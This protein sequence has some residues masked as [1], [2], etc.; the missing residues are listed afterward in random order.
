ML[1]FDPNNP[2]VPAAKGMIV[3]L[4]ATPPV[5]PFL[6]WTNHSLAR[7]KAVEQ[8]QLPKSQFSWVGRPFSGVAAYSSAIAPS[9][10][11][12]LAVKH[13]ILQAM[14]R[15]ESS[16]PFFLQV[17]VSMSSGACAGLIASTA[18]EAIAQTQTL[19]E[20]KLSFTGAAKL[21]VKRNGYHGL[22]RGGVAIGWREAMFQS[23]WMLFAPYISAQ[24]QGKF[25]SKWMC[26]GMSS[27]IIGSLLG[28]TTSFCNMLRHR[29]QYALDVTAP[30]V[31]YRTICREVFRFR[32]ND[33][34]ATFM[35]RLFQGSV[36]R[37]M[38]VSVAIFVMSQ[39]NEAI[40]SALQRYSP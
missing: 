40:E 5:T 33:T 22:F 19:S 18:P 36:P 28:T 14:Q 1:N 35:L 39:A 26:D 8:N 29:K 37:C 20:K 11:V 6:N 32:P 3:G 31:S 24:M 9:A 13:G 16:L 10:A 15:E 21:I 38:A 34:S 25:S 27:F 12:T 30:P 23:G 7:Y 2:F 4:I 17:C